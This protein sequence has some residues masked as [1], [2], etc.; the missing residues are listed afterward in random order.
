M[1]KRFLWSIMWLL[2]AAPAICQVTSGSITGFVIDQKKEGM[3]G[4]TL[5]A[6]HLPSGTKYGSVTLTDGGFQIQN[7]RT[8]GPYRVTVSYPGYEQATF[9]D[10]WLVLDEPYELRAVLQQEGRELQGVTVSAARNSGE[11]TG[12]GINISQEQLNAL[13]TITRSVTD[14]TRLTPQSG[15]GFSTGLNNGNSFAGR[16]GRYNNVQINGA[17][18][19]NS[20]GLNTALFPGSA[21][22][23]SL[24]ALSEVRVSISPYDVRQSGFTGANINAV[25]RSGTNTM[26][27]SAYMYWRNQNFSGVHVGDADL[28]DQGG[29]T[30]NIYGFRLGGPIIKDKL[31]F[32][33]N[34]EHERFIYS[35]VSWIASR[36][37][38]SGPNVS[39][40]PAD[41][42]ELLAA[43]LRNKFGY[44]PGAY[45]DYGNTFTNK[46]TKFLARLDYNV[47]R[48][49]KLYLIYSQMNASEDQQVHPSSAAG[50]RV[51]N[52]R[53]GPNSLV[54]EN[55]NYSFDHVVRSLTA[56]LASNFSGRLANQLLASYSY[57]QDKRRTPGELF[58]FVDIARSSANINDNYISFGTEL[59]SYGT[60]IK[61]TNFSLVNNLSYSTGSHFVTFGLSY[62]YTGFANSFMPYGN[63]YYRFASVSDFINDRAPVVFGYTYPY[64]EQEG[65]SY[66]KAKYGQGSLYLQDKY[67]F[68]RDFVVTA[69]IRLEMP[70]Y[71]YALPSNRYIDTL[72]LPD[73][74][75]NKQHYDVS[76]WPRQRLLA[77]PRLSFNWDINGQRRYQ[78][79][80]GTG[81]FTG[82]VPFVWFTNQPGNTGTLTNQVQITNA[83]ALTSFG[84]NPDARNPL[85][86]L[87]QDTINK[88]FPQHAGASV[89]GQ[90]ALVSPDFR[91]PA[92]W[93]SN[94][95][96]DF[97]LP[98][99]LSATA[100]VIYTKDII[101]VY[102]RNANLPAAS[103]QLNNGSDQRD[104]WSSNRIYNNVSGVYVLENTNKGESYSA[105]IGVSRTVVKGLSGIAYYTATYSADISSN[106]GSQ[107]NSAWN[108]LPS[109]SSPN[110]QALGTSQYLTPHRIIAALSWRLEYRK[111]F[112]TTISVLYEGCSAG[113]FSYLYNADINKDG[114]NADLIY[115]PKD[116][117][118][119]QWADIKDKDGNVVYTA[120]QQAAAFNTYIDQDRY[121]SDHRGAYAGKYAAKYPFY[122][123]FD[124]KLLQDVFFKLGKQQH[125]LQLSADLMNAG[126]LL[127][128]SWGVQQRLVVGGGN[129]AP[130]LNV[131]T[132]GN[133]TTQPIYQMPV[134]TD[135]KGKLVLPYQTFTDN[136]SP[137]STWALQLGVR[138]LF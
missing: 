61:N 114:T 41:S 111:H 14:F 10:I 103:G 93:R 26:M 75:G 51:S 96:L 44:E 65:N 136:V 62:E 24:D 8:G 101:G 131:A 71:T 90:I 4:A 85:S 132:A 29:A 110:E 68:T 52:N 66:V 59:F 86:G 121:L 50:S 18:F 91:M 58:P 95:S 28:P 135:T 63:S 55:S 45:E 48:K 84:F 53:I 43:Y 100:G 19:N 20:F 74:E 32:F 16:D 56:E 17:N 21:Q 27:G 88:Y 79:R 54:F 49:H 30:N 128:P 123:R 5:E 126:N 98:L 92:V 117:N 97:R 33:V 116:A 112:A 94:L 130:I 129:A 78:L 134:V 115:I 83:A 106:P 99:G 87:P 82:R 102:Q 76:N 7:M 109:T 11:R 107:P 42:L 120:A 122:S 113:R 34:A 57:V 69:G 70:F 22:P 31:F 138:Y 25:T 80:G 39:S 46:N 64:Q 105:S 1:G 133:E 13:P 35:G 108:A 36:N 104:Y 137:V 125:T 9:A 67:H 118:E 40:V 15:P 119:L 2:M 38:I 6:V 12:A 127:N 23:V 60:D 37:G 72:M 77:S 47:S 3:P 81:I 73:A 124:V 89:P